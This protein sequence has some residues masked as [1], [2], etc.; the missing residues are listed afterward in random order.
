MN[1]EGAALLLGVLLLAACPGS[2]ADP[3]AGVTCAPGRKCVN[4]VCEGTTQRCAGVPGWQQCRPHDYGPFYVQEEGE[5]QCDGRDNDCD[6][7]TDEGAV[8][9]GGDDSCTL[10]GGEGICGPAAN[11]GTDRAIS[12]PAIQAGLKAYPRPRST[13]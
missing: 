7:E 3:C 2:T 10:Y 12:R 1:A 6:G 9:P 8:Y 5:G 4:G 13:A 11:A